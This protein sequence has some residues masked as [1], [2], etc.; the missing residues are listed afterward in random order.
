MAVMHR[1]IMVRHVVV[2]ESADRSVFLAYR[3]IVGYMARQFR[4]YVK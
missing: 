1:K 3:D 2:N 4:Y